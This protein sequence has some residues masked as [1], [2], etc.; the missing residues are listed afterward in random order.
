[1]LCTFEEQI[2]YLFIISWQWSHIVG[3]S[4]G[5][6]C[7]SWLGWFVPQVKPNSGAGGGWRLWCY[8]QFSQTAAPCTSHSEIEEGSGLTVVGGHSQG[9]CNPLGNHTP[10]R[11]HRHKQPSIV[12][13]SLLITLSSSLN[14]CWSAL[15]SAHKHVLK[16][17]VRSSRP[18]ATVTLSVSLHTQKNKVIIRPTKKMCIHTKELRPCGGQ[19]GK[20]GWSQSGQEPLEPS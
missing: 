3:V 12:S 14:T 9:S 11:T 19:T 16:P 5:H 8:L 1:M 15:Q 13:L 17:D 18:L 2:L 20:P 7:C 4:N 6:L 10:A